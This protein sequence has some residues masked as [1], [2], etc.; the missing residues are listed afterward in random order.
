M[1]K[2]I[3]TDVSE[4]QLE[5]LVRR[6]AGLI[7][8]GL[9][10]VDH[11]KPA[12]GGR[13]DVLMVD[14][15]KSLV[16]AELKVIQDDGMLL[17]GLDYYDY[18]SMHVESFARLYRPHS[19]D[20]TQQV[21]LFLVAPSFSQTLI[22]RCKWLDIP[23]S[24]Y[25]FNCLTFEGDNEIVPI[26]AEQQIPALPPP[27]EVITP[28]QVLEYITDDGV[29]ARVTALLE[30]IERWKPGSIS[31]TAIKG[32]ISMRVG[33][34]V[35]AYLWPRRQR[36]AIQTY[37]A[38]DAWKQYAVDSDDDLATVKPIVRAA[39]ERRTK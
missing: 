18:V 7:E 13:L 11:Q 5:D 32:G 31:I 29:R 17:Q 36:Y 37:D 30:E 2:Y 3:K 1:K 12:A 16:V 23:V 4:Q 14:S 28:D 22:N 10:Y 15:G 25:M 33:G 26:F 21:R 35:F 34:R 27:P 39:M 8:E 38:D 9:V 24:L 19:I 6:N 20:P